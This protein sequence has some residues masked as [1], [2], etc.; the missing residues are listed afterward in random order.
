MRFNNCVYH[1]KPFDVNPS[2]KNACLWIVDVFE[3]S[4]TVNSVRSE[5]EIWEEKYF[6]FIVFTCFRSRFRFEWRHEQKCPLVGALWRNCSTNNV[7][8]IAV[9]LA[10][11]WW[12]T[13]IFRRAFAIMSIKWM[14][15][16]E[17][18]K[19]KS[20]PTW[21]PAWIT[22]NHSLNNMKWHQM[23]RTNVFRIRGIYAFASIQRKR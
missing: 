18:A 16:H 10:T 6:V 9:Y 21:S 14:T 13:E 8:N 3:C 5:N 1:Q 7:W 19:N 4:R 23:N 12:L 2:N 17:R 15:S 11:F 22:S 20:R